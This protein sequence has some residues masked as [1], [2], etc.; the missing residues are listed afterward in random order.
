MKILLVSHGAFAE[1][2]ASTVTNFFG[3]DNIYSACVTLEN[4]TAE[5]TAKLEKY[6]EEWGDEQV[7]ICSD[8][9]CGSAN[10]TVM[11]YIKRPNTFLISGMNLP[12]LLQLHMETEV[13]AEGLREMITGAKEDMEL[14]NDMDFGFDEEDE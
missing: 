9:K 14:I 4:G 11:P 3:A 2:I 8:I 12:L 7:V 10:Q 5:L 6:F 1:G 13:T